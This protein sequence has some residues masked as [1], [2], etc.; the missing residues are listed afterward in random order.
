MRVTQ[1]KAAKSGDAQA[2]DPVEVD[3]EELEQQL[4]AKPK[5]SPV[6]VA[7]FETQVNELTDLE[8]CI[9]LCVFHLF[10]FIFRRF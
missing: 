6:V 1:N 10:I 5:I 9:N 3:L 7:G 2:P 4:A 8:Y